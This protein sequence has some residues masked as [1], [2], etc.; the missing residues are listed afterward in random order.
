MYLAHVLSKDAR[1][2]ILDKF[3]PKFPDVIAHHVTIKIGVSTSEKIPS[4]AKVTVIGYIKDESLEALVVTVN[5]KKFRPDGKRYH[6]TLSLDRSKGRTPAQSNAL[7]LTKVFDT[8]TPFEIK[9]TPEL[10]K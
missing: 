5:D 7:I 8:V 6:I 4:P 10:S 3:P 1:K 2:T 9:T